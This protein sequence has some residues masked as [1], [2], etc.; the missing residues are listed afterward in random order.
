MKY[1]DRLK[2]EKRAPR[3]TAKTVKSQNEAPGQT[4]KTVKTPFGTFDSTL[5]RRFSGNN[6]PAR[7]KITRL[8][9]ARAYFQ[10][11][12]GRGVQ[13]DPSNCKYVNDA[14]PF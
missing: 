1:L 12:A 11:R 14:E 2:S 6:C 5:G 10:G 9:Y 3:P 7:C 4:V 8:C 13:C